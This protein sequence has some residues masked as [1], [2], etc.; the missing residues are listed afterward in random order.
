LLIS[1]VPII[2]GIV[3]FVFLV[4]DSQPDEN[5]YGPNPKRVAV[6]VY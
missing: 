1:F 6:A 2:G 4:T 3:L 5:Q